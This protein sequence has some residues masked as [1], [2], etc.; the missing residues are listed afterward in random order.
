MDS[1]ELTVKREKLVQRDFLVLQVC[2]QV[3]VVVQEARV[4]LGDSGLTVREV[5]MPL[6]LAM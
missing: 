3:L 6:K 1:M 2:S 4:V 5:L